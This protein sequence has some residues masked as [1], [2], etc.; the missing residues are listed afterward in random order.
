MKL[1]ENHSDSLFRGCRWKIRGNKC[2]NVVIRCKTV[3][4]S[5][6]KK[7]YKKEMVNHKNKLRYIC[8]LRIMIILLDSQIKS[9]YQ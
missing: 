3:I 6:E 8:K 4:M 1:M 5:Q 9:N 7:N 2:I